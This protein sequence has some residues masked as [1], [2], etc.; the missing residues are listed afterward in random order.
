MSTPCCIAV[1][2][3]KGFRSIQCQ[4]DGYPS[5]VGKMLREHYDH[6]ETVKALLRL[7]DL[8]VLGEELG[9]QHDFDWV[10]KAPAD[11]IASDPRFKMCRAYGRDRGETGCRAR[12]RRSFAGLVADAED[13]GAKWLY[14]RF[15]E[16]WVF[17]PMK[18]GLRWA[19][20]T[21]LTE[22]ACQIDS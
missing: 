22:K 5:G 20:T 16:A 21:L 13:G 6:S 17:A 18:P 15:G 7:G 10:R 19:D 3:A 8:S 2:S 11:Q 9:E 4:S 1:G 12:Y 14:V